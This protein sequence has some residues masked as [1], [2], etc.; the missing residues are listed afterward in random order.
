MLHD[1]SPM[2]DK[3]R[4]FEL[5]DK[6]REQRFSRLLTTIT[7]LFFLFVRVEGRTIADSFDGNATTS[8]AGALVP[9]R[10]SETAAIRPAS[11]MRSNP[12]DAATPRL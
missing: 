2:G 4:R 1:Y 6:I 8:D 3:L 11:S 10:A 7:Q 9:P 5:P 12:A